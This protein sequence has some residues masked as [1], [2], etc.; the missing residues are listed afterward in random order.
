MKKLLVCGLT[1]L[2][3]S[4]QAQS[5]SQSVGTIPAET[6]R[7]AI[8]REGIIDTESGD[9]GKHL[10]WDVSLWGWY[11]NDPL[12]IVFRDDDG[13]KIERLVSDRVGASLVGSLSLLDWLQLG[14][15]IPFIIYQNGDSSSFLDPSQHPTTFSNGGWLGLRDIR[16]V[17]KVRLLTAEKHHVNLSLLGHIVLPT[18]TPGDQFLGSEGFWGEPMLAASRAY[19]GGFRWTA[20]VGYLLRSPYFST[21]LDIGQGFDLRAGVG[22]DLEA[23]TDIPLGINWSV[24]SDIQT[25]NGR[26]DSSDGFGVR[27][28]NSVETSVGV[29]Y[30]INEALQVFGGFGMGLVSGPGTPDWRLFAGLRY[31]PQGCSDSDEDGICNENDQCPDEPEDKDGFQD[32]EGCPDPD[33]DQDGILDVD[34]KCPI[35]PEDRDTFEDENGCPDPD[36]DQ[37][38]VLDVDDKCPSVKG[39]AERSG[40]PVVDSDQDGILDPDDNCPNEKGPKDNQG[41]PNP[42]KDGD[43]ILDVDDACPEKAGPA[44][45]K[46][47]PDSD[48][49][50]FAD[51]VDKCPNEPEVINGVD[52]DDG[53]PDKGKTLVKLTAD[54]IEIKESVYFATGKSAIK[55][56][57]FNLL[58]QVSAVLKAH[59]EIKRCRV[60]GHTDSR[61][62][63]KSNLRLSQARAASVKQY[64]IDQGIDPTRLESEGYGETRPVA[65]NNTK[66]GRQANRRVDFFVV[67][68]AK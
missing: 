34:D 8:D 3:M 40:C 60:E 62:S 17:P 23:S 16:I 55:E 44:M 12:N 65:D 10:D 1:M 38:G 4:V 49:D 56:R 66:A 51:Q 26:D 19:D 9:V 6:F 37:D 20:N 5:S 14:I 15:E 27:Y 30:D 21:N 31:A 64:L 29:D 68:Q 50:G 18:G 47:C 46:G 28:D 33:N 45:F 42:D 2:A 13:E 53:C 36:N 24:R 57:S 43:G 11:A 63:D 41:C 7:P 25:T 59:P 48:G 61:G 32:E 54:K 67:D 22:Y 39:D 35:E 58:N 52:D